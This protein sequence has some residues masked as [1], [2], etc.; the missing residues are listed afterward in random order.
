V[1]RSGDAGGDGG[2]GGDG[3]GDGGDGGNVDGWAGGRRPW[4]CMR[5]ELV[6]LVLVLLVLVVLPRVLICLDHVNAVGMQLL[7]IAER[8]VGAAVRVQRSEEV[9]QPAHDRA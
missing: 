3:D 4:C 9:V 6:A 1:S 8:K 5:Y 7:H 2:G